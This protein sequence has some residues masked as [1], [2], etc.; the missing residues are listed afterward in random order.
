VLVCVHPL[1][2][3]V[4]WG[5]AQVDQAARHV[6]GALPG[7]GVGGSCTLASTHHEGTGPAL[8]TSTSGTRLPNSLPESFFLVL[9]FL[10]T[11]KGERERGRGDGGRRRNRRNNSRSRGHIPNYRRA[12]RAACWVLGRVIAQLYLAPRPIS[13]MPK[14]A[15]EQA[16]NHRTSN[17]CDGS[18]LTQQAVHIVEWRLRNKIGKAKLEGRY[19][20]E[21]EQ[22]LPCSILQ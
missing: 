6:A 11:L 16:R 9:L 1:H 8:A 4:P 10:S 5:C 18:V 22:A 19:G 21:S 3:S 13:P 17:P 14:G 7:G 12:R 20:R 2:F 15:G